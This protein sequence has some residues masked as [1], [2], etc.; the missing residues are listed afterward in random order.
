VYRIKTE[1]SGQDPTKLCRAIIITTV[2]IIIVI[3]NV[4]YSNRLEH[5]GH[6]AHVR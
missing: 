3:N 1:K 2:I 4:I 6:A 5:I